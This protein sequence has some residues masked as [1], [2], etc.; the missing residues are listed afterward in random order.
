MKNYNNAITLAL[1]KV[2]SYFYSKA[3]NM[4]QSNDKY[5]IREAYNKLN[6]IE[7]ENPKYK[8]T[9]TLMQTAHAK[10]TSHVLVSISNMFYFLKSEPIS[11]SCQLSY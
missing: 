4:I 9:R 1:D 6:Y 2:S 7:T 8:N 10:G 3:Q 11:I 5:V